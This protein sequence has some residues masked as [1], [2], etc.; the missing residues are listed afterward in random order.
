MRNKILQGFFIFLLIFA[1]GAALAHEGIS[2]REWLGHVIGDPFGAL[3]HILA[4][5][6]LVLGLGI[7]VNKQANFASRFAGAIMALAGLSLFFV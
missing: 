5:A 1:P 2:P 4:T 3:D 6:S 7:L